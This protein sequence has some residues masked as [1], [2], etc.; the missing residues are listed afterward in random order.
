MADKLGTVYFLSSSFVSLPAHFYG[1]GSSVQPLLSLQYNSK[2]MMRQG[3]DDLDD[4]FVPD[5]LVALSDG[6]ASDPGDDVQNLLSADEEAEEDGESDFKP[7][8]DKGKKRKRREKEKERKAKV[9]VINFE[10]ALRAGVVSR[11]LIRVFVENKV[12]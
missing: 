6:I 10:T 1:I 11:I 9:R 7:K 2:T 8:S 5:D 12:S 3:G 4:D